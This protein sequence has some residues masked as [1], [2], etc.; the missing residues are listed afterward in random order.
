M[1]N[2]LLIRL[3]AL[4]RR[5][6]VE[7]ELDDELR[8]HFDRQVEKFVQSGLPLAEA[9][10]RARLEFG[11][12]DHIKEECREARGVHLLETLTQD[13]R[14]PLRMLR[15]NPGFTAIAILT[16]ALGIGANTAI[17]SVFYSVLLRPLPYPEQDRLVFIQESSKRYPG[18]TVSYPNFLAW[19]EQQRS[20]TA[21][22]VARPDNFNYI[23]SSET[24]QLRGAEVSHD[25]FTVIGMA[26]IRG[27]LFTVEDDKPGAKRTV[28]IR[29]SLWKRLF[30]E[31]DS[32]IGETI[33][34]SGAFYTIIG[35]L[36]DELMVP[37]DGAELWI[38]VSLSLSDNDLKYYYRDRLHAFGRL[39][40]GVE[41]ESARAEMRVLAIQLEREHPS[42]EFIPI[43][44]P[45][46]AAYTGQV[47]PTLY[48][49]LGA[50][51]FVL[52]IA[53]AN[54]ANLQLA[55]AHARSREFAV[56]AALGSGRGRIVRQLLVEGLIVGLLDV[57]RA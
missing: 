45:L 6:T 27:R 21:I 34:L 29:S 8:F 28:V 44:S 1:L 53:C 26:P 14:F 48:V 23:G 40:Q 30:G 24:E 37:L 4:F 16:L 2:D 19:R 35:V 56:R 42:G 51:G 39:K 54:V 46:S 32:V 50:A 41:L 55:R 13:I 31:R 10:R 11:G 25:L 22:G 7:S 12:S 3:R 18:D 52:L 38:P 9:R 57:A 5:N 43:L 33:N 15:K 36:P 47:R 20:F 49:L 17:F